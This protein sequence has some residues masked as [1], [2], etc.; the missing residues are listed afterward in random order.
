MPLINFGN[1]GSLANQLAG[2]TIRRGVAQGAQRLVDNAAAPVVRNVGAINDLIG[3]PGGKYGARAMAEMGKTAVPSVLGRG[4]VERQVGRLPP[5]LGVP[6]AESHPRYKEG[7]SSATEFLKQYGADVRPIERQVSNLIQNNGLTQG[8][9]NTLL[10]PSTASTALNSRIP[11]PGIVKSVL[12]P[13]SVAGSVVGLLS[14]EGSTPQS[15]RPYSRWRQLG[16]CSEQDMKTRVQKTTQASDS[17]FTNLHNNQRQRQAFADAVQLEADI[18]AGAGT[19]TGT[20]AGAGAGTGTAVGSGYSSRPAP[21]IMGTR[22]GKTVDRTQ[23]DMYKQALSQYQ[24]TVPGPSKEALGMQTWARTPGNPLLAAKVQPGQAGYD[25]I[26]QELA[27]QAFK[28]PGFTGDFGTTS[29]PQPGAAF[30]APVGGLNF[31]PASSFTGLGQQ[32]PSQ[33]EQPELG[34]EGSVSDR[35]KQFLDMLTAVGKGQ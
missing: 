25:I 17:N 35:T 2:P 29:A 20:G 23:S 21:I 11:L 32:Q 10:S 9:K 33:V 31:S 8:L 6:K 26:Q 14:L 28:S 16:Y 5:L 24:N 3:R 1:V 7:Y 34:E 13:T 15:E 22:D 19:G 4:L 30:N 12:F 18:R 27:K